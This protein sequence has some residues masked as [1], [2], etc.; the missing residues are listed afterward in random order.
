MKIISFEDQND[1]TCALYV[2]LADYYMLPARYDID[3]SY[4][5][6]LMSQ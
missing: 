5:S 2:R 6:R 1:K 3:G 4:F